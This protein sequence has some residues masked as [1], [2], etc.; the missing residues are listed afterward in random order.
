MVNSGKSFLTAKRSLEWFFSLGSNANRLHNNNKV[1]A[2]YPHYLNN[3]F[4]GFS[5][6]AQKAKEYRDQL[7]SQIAHQQLLQKAEEEKRKKEHESN[8]ETE[9]KYQERLQLIL[10]MPN[11][12]VIKLPTMKKA[13]MPDS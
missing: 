6:K 7:T 9:R 12:S 4:V 13:L 11:E 2:F 8:M 1:Y 10:S 5:R 3:L